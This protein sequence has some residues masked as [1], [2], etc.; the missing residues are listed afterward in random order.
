MPARELTGH[1][2]YVFAAEFS[3]DGRQLATGSADGTVKLWDVARGKC[4]ATIKRH[5]NWVYVLAYS[6]DGGT[7]ISGDYDGLV[8]RHNAATGRPWVG[9]YKASQSIIGL[10]IHPG[11]EQVACA[12]Y[13]RQID[14]L[15][16]SRLEHL[17][18]LPGR[19]G[20]IY[21]VRYSPDGS[22]LAAGGAFRS[23]QLYN[24]ESRKL[25]V[26]LKYRDK[27]GARSLRFT[28]DGRKLFAALPNA[29]RWWNRGKEKWR[30][31]GILTGH[32]EIVS[33]LAVT[34][35]GES[36][37]SAGWDGTV[38]RWDV[39]TGRQTQ[40][41]RWEL[42][43]LFHVTVSPDGRTAAA[44]GDANHFVMWELDD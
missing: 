35:D 39:A 32:T 43:K 8:L 19:P 15:D 12:G 41:W 38:R 27:M 24:T 31:G 44:T 36:L 34:P 2:S 16:A 10:D 9:R 6:P 26:K 33:C 17:Q 30:E 18:T 25:E 7:L 5:E 29:I 40:L 14:L 42:G 1:R 21:G 37:L 28:P 22:L 13:G 23:V 20:L 4:T 3:P 11:G